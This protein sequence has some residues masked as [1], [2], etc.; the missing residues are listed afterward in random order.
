[1]PKAAGFRPLSA[2]ERRLAASIFA[3]RIDYARVQVRRRSFFPLGLQSRTTAMAPNGHLYFHPQ[4]PLYRECFA[5]CAQGSLQ[6]LFI[7]EMAHVWQHQQGQRVWIWAGLEQL[8]R[9]PYGY[10]LKPGKSLAQYGLE[11][12]AEILRHYFYL[13]QI[14]AQAAKMGLS[15]ADLPPYQDTLQAFLEHTGASAGSIRI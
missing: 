6:G 3:D 7:H 5:E 13:R 11:Q 1:M 2:A 10:R 4:S 8:S 15:A 14:P 9:D 12:Q